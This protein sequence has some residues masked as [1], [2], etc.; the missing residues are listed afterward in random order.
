MKNLSYSYEYN[1]YTGN[2]DM[3]SNKSHRKDVK[4]YL[5]EDIKVQ[6]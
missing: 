5:I 6:T 3:C 4:E 1:K 2:I